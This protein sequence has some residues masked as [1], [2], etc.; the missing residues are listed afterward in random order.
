[1]IEQILARMAEAQVLVSPQGQATFVAGIQG[2]IQSV[3]ALSPEQRDEMMAQAQDD[4]GFWPSEDSWLASYRPYRV[5][6]GIL[7][8]PVS[9]SLISEFGWVFQ[10]WVTGYDY[11]RRAYQ[12]GMDDPEVRGIVFKVNSP[13]GEVSGNFD[14]VDFIASRRDEKPTMA[15][16]SDHAYSAAYNIAAAASHVV[17]NRVGGVGSVG[18]VTMHADM[19]E[20]MKKLG[21]GISLVHSGK[22]KVDGNPY[23]PLKPEVRKRMQ[24]RV[25]GLY[26]IFVSTV[27]RNRGMDEQAVRD[28]EALTFSAD[29]GVE[30][31]LADAVQSFDD[32][33]AAF[34]GKL[35]NSDGAFH[36]ATE[37][38]NQ[39]S[40]AASEATQ[41]ARQA[42]Y[43]AGKADGIKEGM[44]AE[45]ERVQGILA[46]DA[47]Q[48]RPAAALN[49]SMNTQLTV[50]EA[51]KVLAGLPEES[52]P[53]AT[54]GGGSH[55][56]DA[57]RNGNPE[58]SG[59]AAADAERPGEDASAAI[60]RDFRA[61]SGETKTSH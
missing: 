7:T 33:M 22:H 20:Y 17:V 9:G 57:M 21:I 46:C 39:P 53:E 55:F 58:I 47:A 56:A 51:Q 49:L 3:S 42:G 8:I 43:D 29:E 25:D 12:R 18:V 60:L 59:D 61:A 38:K 28:T 6:D 34:A 41:E 24:T 2:M 31:G 13:G 52:K 19:S 44:S 23:E 30:I 40:A 32:A 37:S 10:G 48:Q 5:R 11:I 27:A 16:A 26:G 14:L 1:M 36:M 35:A 45:R 15:A 54:K 4:D 50:D